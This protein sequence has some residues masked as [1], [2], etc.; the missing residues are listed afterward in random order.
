MLLEEDNNVDGNE[1]Y[2]S[3]RLLAKMMTRFGKQLKS[4]TSTHIY[5]DPTHVESDRL[6][7]HT[8]EQ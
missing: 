2:H 1:I 3:F 6:F 7:L 8:K 4:V 5:L